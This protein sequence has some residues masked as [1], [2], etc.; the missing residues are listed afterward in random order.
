M[1]VEG[2]ALTVFFWRTSEGIPPRSLFCSLVAGAGLVLALFA[3]LTGAAWQWI[4]A[5]LIFSLIG[6]VA[7]VCLRWKATN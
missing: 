5:A 4:A 3:A 7:D 2:V 1:V 6:H